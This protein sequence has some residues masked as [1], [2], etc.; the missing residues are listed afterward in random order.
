FALQERTPSAKAPDLSQSRIEFTDHEADMKPSSQPKRD[1]PSTEP[2]RQ[3]IAYQLEED[4]YAPIRPAPRERRWM[5][6]AG[7]KFPYR[8]LP[9]V[10][11]NQYG[12][13]ILSTHHVRASWDGTSKPSG[14]HIEN[15]YGDG[16]LHCHSNF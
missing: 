6:L 8:C 16:T 4:D 1:A 12:W 5:E 11:A 13:E 9:L 7:D 15:L 10:V 2:V 3:L 14:V